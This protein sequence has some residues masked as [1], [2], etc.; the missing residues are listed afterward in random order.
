MSER[1]QHWEN[2]YETKS[3]DEV[4]WYEETPATSLSLIIYFIKIGLTP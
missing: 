2:V 4:S 3:D 1:K